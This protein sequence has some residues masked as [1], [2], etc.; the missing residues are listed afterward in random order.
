[1]LMDA[2]CVSGRGDGQEHLLWRWGGL[3]VCFTLDIFYTA[4]LFLN[5]HVRAGVLL[6][7]KILPSTQS[8]TG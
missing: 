7:V 6:G 5:G 3:N 8:S 4:T 2:L 1:M